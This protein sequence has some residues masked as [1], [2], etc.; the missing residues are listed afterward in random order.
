MQ[1][2]VIGCGPGGMLAAA[3][4]ADAGLPVLVVAPDLDVVWPNRY[5]VFCDELE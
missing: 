3:A 4:C 1:V 5:G 2:V